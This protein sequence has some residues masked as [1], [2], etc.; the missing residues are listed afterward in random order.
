MRRLVL[1]AALLL[2]PVAH[3]LTEAEIREQVTAVISQRHPKDS[4]DWWRGLGPQAPRILIRMHD[5][6][7]RASHKLRLLQG[8][9]W[10]DDPAAT[11]FL[12]QQ[13]RSS[14]NAVTRAASVRTLGLSQG[15]K[16]L[17]FLVEMLKDADPDIRFA[18]AEAVSR[19]SGPK[20]QGALEKYRAEEK[21]PW[22]LSKLKGELPRPGAPAPFKQPGEGLSPDFEGTWKGFW[23]SPK[24]PH[25]LGSDEAVF[26]LS[27][28][29][30][31]KLSGDLSIAAK[32][33]RKTYKLG[34][35]TGKG[36]RVL[37]TLLDPSPKRNAAPLAGPSPRP[38]E[39][40]ASE[41]LA[42]EAELLPPQAGGVQLLQ[43][44]AAR[45][46]ATLI[47]RK[48]PQR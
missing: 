1:L 7:D 3:A 18:A 13:A 14:S 21:V 2:G 44:R 42:F 39:P 47:V 10:F 9:A 36:S 26:T 5:E 16:E 28:D 35:V 43:L 17:P 46:G 33:K 15:E 23:I 41:E 12:K 40:S 6:T 38:T 11:D 22:V 37:G 20:A 31:G 29:A 4:P 25:G 32:P 34:G 48:E 27:I 45:T 24:A 19:V 30:S 8:L